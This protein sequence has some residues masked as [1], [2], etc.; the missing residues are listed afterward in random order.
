M[1]RQSIAC[2]VRREPYINSVGLS[3]L[4]QEI[5]SSVLVVYL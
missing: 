1:F 2:S 3:E 4:L 5:Q